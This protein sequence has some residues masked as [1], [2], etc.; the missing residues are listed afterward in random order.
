M[1]LKNLYG[2]NVLVSSP[3]MHSMAK[4]IVSL[5][6]KQN[7]DFSH[8]KADYTNFANGEI[9]T[10]NTRNGTRDTCVFTLCSAGARSKQRY[11]I[12]AID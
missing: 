2:G 11:N 7:N 9:K 8:I 5:L 12:N 4:I 6:N 1:D 3:G 10:Q